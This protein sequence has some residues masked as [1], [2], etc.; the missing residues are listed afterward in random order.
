MSHFTTLKTQF[1][2]SE[3]LLKALEDVRAEFALGPVRFN[4]LV[5]GFKGHTTPA[6]IVLATAHKGFD[7]GFRCD[8]GVYHLVADWFGITGITEAQLL[9]RLQQRYACHAARHQLQKQGFALVEETV[10][11]DQSVRLVLRRVQ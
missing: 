1:V 6:H 8:E 7:I 10:Q 2:A 4:E 5:G 11:Q 9:G 3:F